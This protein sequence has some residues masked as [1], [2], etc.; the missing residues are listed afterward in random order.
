VALLLL[1]F[2]TG[3]SALSGNGQAL[4]ILM[5]HDVVEDGQPYNTWTVTAGGVSPG[6]PGGEDHR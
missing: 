3:D 1:I 2:C 5:Y 6:P 4:P